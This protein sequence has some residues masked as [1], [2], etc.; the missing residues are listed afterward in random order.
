MSCMFSLLTH[1][2][3]ALHSVS[4]P[5]I[6]CYQLTITKSLCLETEPGLV[7]S[8]GKVNSL[9]MAHLLDQV[10]WNTLEQFTSF[11]F[12]YW[13]GNRLYLITYNCCSVQVNLFIMINNL[14]EW[15]GQTNQNLCLGMD[16]P[17]LSEKKN[18]QQV[19]I[20]HIFRIVIFS[21]V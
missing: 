11:L 19:W 12:I 2:S 18:Q 1:P 8:T 13:I 6:E 15:Y 3:K 10:G 4:F 16:F 17:L 14:Y 21:I 20:K 7:R 5:S 9:W